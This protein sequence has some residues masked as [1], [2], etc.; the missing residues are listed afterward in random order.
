MPASAVSSLQV[1]AEWWAAA[2]LPVESLNQVQLTGADPVLPSSFHVGTAAQVSIAAAALAACE[3]AQVRGAPR[4]M[5]SVDMLA[6]AQEC[7][8]WFSVDGVVPPK[9]DPFSGLYRCADGWVRIHANFAH[10]RDG[11]LRLLGLA[12]ETAQP[13]DVTAALQDWRAEAFETAAAEQRL[14]VAALRDFA[15][16]DLHPQA[17]ALKTQPLWTLERIGDAP[18][19]SLPALPAEARPLHGVR[20]LDL[21][22]IL[23]GPV[24]GRTLAA[25]GADVMLVNAPHL[26]NIASIAETSRGKR[27]VL[28]DLRSL[29]GRAD[30]AAL[31]QGSHVMLQ[32]Y[33]PGGLQDLG[34][35]P[36]QAAAQRP[37]IVYVSLSAY[38]EHGPWCQRRGFD[39]LVQT[40]T[41]FNQ[42]EGLAAGQAGPKALPV[43]ILDYASGF[44]MAAAAAVALR[45][46]QL[47]GGS[48]LVRLSLAQTAQWLRQLGRVEAGF[49]T[50]ETAI[51]PWLESLDSG[52]GRL[53]A[54]RHA[55]QLSRTPVGWLR[56][57]VPPGSDAPHWID[58]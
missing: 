32:G 56:P 7:T 38:G 57:S 55:A 33:R 25:Y 18:P 2:G 47:E 44:F 23:A 50:A 8:G 11:A 17:L 21:T 46:Q 28:A 26:P 20:V 3:L 15:T 6:A 35:G 40:A 10:H 30:F 58:G 1:L 14:V 52:F 5:L 53:Q 13:A 37:G 43:Q 12:P 31:L 27:S 4:Q 29:A 48:W 36:E 39:S 34:F 42:A 54:V 49:A 19:L 9:W 16:W 45:R 41:G 24:G 22:R 51:T